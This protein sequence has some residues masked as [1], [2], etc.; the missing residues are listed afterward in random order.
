MELIGFEKQKKYLKDAVAADRLQHAY[1]F[2]GPDMIGKKQLAFWLAELINDRPIPNSD[3]RILAPRKEDDE[4]HIYIED[5]KD[6]RTF[7]SMKPAQGPFKV[8]IID[9]ADALTTEA[10]NS[11]L[12]SLE[13]P[14][15]KTLLILISSRPESVLPT[16][17]SRCLEVK[18][19]AHS[20]EAIAGVVDSHGLSSGDL[21]LIS[22]LAGGRIGWVIDCLEN[23]KLPVLKKAV[24]DFQSV[25]RQGTAERMLYIKKISETGSYPELI[26][27]WIRWVRAH[28]KNP[29]K[30]RQVLAR[31]LKLQAILDQPQFHH[32]LALENFLIN[33]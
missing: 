23:K 5:I 19:S 25:V 30:T 1:F 14:A 6:A 11:F 31:L 26:P 27:V 17:R 7:L 12:K 18:F 33:I 8:V 13:E 22:L 10:A 2:T 9:D 24:Q 20:A 28:G 16:L 29:E 4:S 15:V 3:V 21:E 32:R